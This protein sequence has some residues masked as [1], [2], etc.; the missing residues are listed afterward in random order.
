[1]REAV[2]FGRESARRNQEI[3]ACVVTAT[4]VTEAE[5][6][7]HCRRR[8]SS[9]QTPRH[10][11]FLAEIPVNARGKISRRELAEEYRAS[12]AETETSKS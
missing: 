8:L 1:V 9:W 4:G 11:F 3:A 5:L 10:I 12:H 2:V 6:L 7:A